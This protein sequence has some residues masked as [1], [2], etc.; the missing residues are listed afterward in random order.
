MFRWTNKAG[1]RRTVYA[2]TI[3]MLR[4]M[5]HQL[6]VNHEY[7]NE[8]DITTLRINELYAM[9]CR[10]KVGIRDNTLA[11]YKYTYETFIKQ[12]FGRN[13]VISIRKSDIREFYESVLFDR[14]IKKSSLGNIHNVLHQV[15]QFGYDEGYIFANPADGALEEFRKIRRMDD[16]RRVALTLSQ[17]TYFLQYVKNNRKW[18]RWYNLLAVLAGTGMRISEVAGLRWKDINMKE[19]YI[20]VNH[21]LV[22]K[23]GGG[24]CFFTR[25][26]TPRQQENVN[27]II[28]HICTEYNNEKM[29]AGADKEEFLPYFTCHILRHSFATRLCEA[30]VNLKVVQYIMGHTD[31]NTT[32]NVYTS[33]TGMMKGEAMKTVTNYLSW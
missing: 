33:V 25:E 20:D 9:W 5:E 2:D 23:R 29:A 8:V 32:L 7:D 16:D 17:E 31:L 10:L 22:H 24:R 6:F 3:S 21:A 1:I 27:K 15:L 14:N 4:Y 19:G 12:G 13:K 30:G 28:H 26:N 18:E 11:H